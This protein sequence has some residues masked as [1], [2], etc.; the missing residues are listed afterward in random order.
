MQMHAIRG[1]QL[2]AARAMLGLRLQDIQS[3]TGGAVVK[4][5]LCRLERY[6]TATPDSRVE[7]L[8]RAV[9]F[10]EAKGIRFFYHEADGRII[11]AVGLVEPQGERFSLARCAG[12]GA[13]RGRCRQRKTAKESAAK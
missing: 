10:F 6:G 8:A 2:R 4:G 7:T 13:T 11:T 1:D 3:A 5:T 9:S 12:A